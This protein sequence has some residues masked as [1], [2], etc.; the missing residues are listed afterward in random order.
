MVESVLSLA[1]MSI[2]SIQV[3]PKKIILTRLATEILPDVIVTMKVYWDDI[4]TLDVSNNLLEDLPPLPKNLEV[5]KCHNNQI[6]ALPPVPDSL[7]TISVYPNPI[8]KLEL[9]KGIEVLRYGP[10]FRLV[11]EEPVSRPYI[12]MNLPEFRIFK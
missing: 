7:R 11:A 6:K 3:L 10:Q 4:T 8:P 2:K 1:G 9:R 12:H 5:L